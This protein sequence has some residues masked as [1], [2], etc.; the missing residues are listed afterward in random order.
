MLELMGW[1]ILGV[2]VILP[3]AVA[4]AVL[5]LMAEGLRRTHSLRAAGALLRTPADQ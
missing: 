3:I 2:S 5:R 4:G 1:G